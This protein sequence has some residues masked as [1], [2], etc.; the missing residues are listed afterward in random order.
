MFHSLPSMNALRAFEAAARHL[1]FTDAADELFVTPS[2]ISR[3]IRLLEEQLDTKLFIRLTR[4]VKLTDRGQALLLSL[5]SA[6]DTI[7]K[8]TKA[9]DTVIERYPEKRRLTIGLDTDIAKL[10]LSKRLPNFEAMNPDIELELAINSNDSH[11]DLALEGV[12]LE[13]YYG[14]GLKVS[15][16]AELI[17]RCYEFILCSPSLLEKNPLKNLDD[18]QHHKLIHHARFTWWEEFLQDIGAQNVNTAAGWIVHDYSL[19]VDMVLEGRGLMMG[20]DVMCSD[21]LL[22]GQL[23]KPL[24][25]SQPMWAGEGIYLLVDP[26]KQKDPLVQAFR[27]WLLDE[28]SKHEKETTALREPIPYNAN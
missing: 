7:A 18:L 3:Q 28:F 16:Q 5:S 6:F 1:S 19:V 4:E 22:S 11:K 12:E 27:T 17:K 8:A 9:T 21:H 20:D 15:P 10:W 24:P 26:E 23:V 25:Y 13:L 14:N 2:A